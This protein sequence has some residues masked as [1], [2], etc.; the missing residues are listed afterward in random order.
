MKADGT[1]V[2]WGTNDWGQL[3][4]PG[5]LTG[6]RAVAA[7]WYHAL[8]LKS[9]GTVVA[10]AGTTPARRTCLPSW[11]TWWELQRVVGTVWHCAPMVR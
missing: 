1:V 5:G 7:G 2:A 9:G 6:V 4:V 10:W 8:A 11:A 3:N